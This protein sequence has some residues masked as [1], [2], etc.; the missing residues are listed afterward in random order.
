MDIETAPAAEDAQQEPGTQAENSAGAATT[1]APLVESEP[2]SSATTA[3]TAGAPRDIETAP[4][5]EDAQQEPGTQAEHSAGAATTPA[6]L[7]ESE[8]ASSSAGIASGTTLAGIPQAP[9]TQDC[10]VV[11]MLECFSRLTGFPRSEASALYQRLGGLEIRCRLLCSIL[12]RKPFNTALKHDGP[13]PTDFTVASSFW[14]KHANEKG[15]SQEVASLKNSKLPGS[16]TFTVKNA[17][18]FES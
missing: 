16:H 17:F 14:K 13:Q 2:A 4:A 1:P 7:V 11:L 6:P 5:A 9:G 3:A 10:G 12:H 15:S 18:E 8:P